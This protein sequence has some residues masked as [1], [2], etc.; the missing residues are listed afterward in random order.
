MKIFA[1]TCRTLITIKTPVFF[2]YFGLPLLPDSLLYSRDL[3]TEQFNNNHT[4]SLVSTVRPGIKL[5]AL[6]FSDRLDYRNTPSN[7]ESGFHESET[8]SIALYYISPSFD[9]S[10]ERLI[11]RLEGDLGARQGNFLFRETEQDLYFQPYDFYGGFSFCDFCSTLFGRIAPVADESYS[12]Y[13]MNTGHSTGIHIVFAHNDFGELT[14]S[15][16]TVP[17]LQGG[18]PV[19]FDTPETAENDYGHSIFYFLEMSVFHFSMFFEVD[20]SKQTSDLSAAI[21]RIEYSGIGLGLNIP[22]TTNGIQQGNIRKSIAIERSL[23]FYRTAHI[24]ERPFRQAD[25]DG[26]ALLS[27]LS[28]NYGFIESNFLF[29]LPEPATPEQGSIRKIDEI[30]GYIRRSHSPIYSHIISGSLDF[31]PAPT[32]CR[33]EKNCS[34]IYRSSHFPSFR[35]HAAMFQ[36]EI[37]L[38]YANFQLSVKHTIARPLIPKNRQGNPFRSSPFDHEKRGY[39]E[40]SLGFTYQQSAVMGLEYYRLEKRD[41][42][43]NRSLVSEGFLIYFSFAFGFAPEIH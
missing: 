40:S 12:I 10:S 20:N 22:I 16:F 29:F 9:Y 23:G 21:D 13:N 4:Q 6:R 41:Q 7:N 25:I 35:N 19:I 34:G 11:I 33:D 28:I 5:S 15:P 38:I 31:M 14:F 42:A 24:T 39:M 17:D 1:F 3:H 27:E 32:I 37:S 30:S 8:E 43:K 18:R 36:A 26:L 2:L